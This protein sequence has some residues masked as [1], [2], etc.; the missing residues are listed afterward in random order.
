MSSKKDVG[1]KLEKNGAGKAQHIVQH[2][3]PNG[4]LGWEVRTEGNKQAD[5]VYKTQAEAIEAAKA[6]AKKHH[7]AVIIHSRDG[8]VRS[9]VSYSPA[10]EMMLKIWKDT[11]ENHPKSSRR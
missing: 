7:S 11:Y 10:D 3:A 5:R 8:R 1:L 9:Q 2:I 4:T 6:V